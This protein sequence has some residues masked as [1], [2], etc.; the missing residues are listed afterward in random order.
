MKLHDLRAPKGAKKNRKR[1]GRGISAGGGKT[2]GRG[3]K[4]QNKRSGGGKG[5]Y[6]EGGQLPLVRRLP[7]LRGFTNRSRVQYQ[8]VNVAL[9]STAF[10]A[11]SEVTPG[12][13]ADARMIR[14]SGGPVVILGSGKID[15]ALHVKAQRFSRSA[16][17]KIE[18]AGGTIEILDL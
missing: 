10:E 3:E 13:M 18:A 12:V 15:V 17:E 11:D 4:G 5:P 1:V 6:F 9:L 8:P 7:T 14:S 2:A 16:R